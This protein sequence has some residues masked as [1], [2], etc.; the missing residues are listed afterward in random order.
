M[1][2]TLETEHPQADGLGYLLHKHPGKLQSF[3]QSFGHAHVFYPKNE[4]NRSKIAILL[5]VDPVGLVRRKGGPSGEGF[6]LDQYVN[7]RGYVAS[8]FMSVTLADLFSTAMNGRCKDKPELVETV[9]PFIAHLPALPCRGG[10]VFL[11]SLFEPLGYTVEAQCGLLD[12][13]FPEW[14]FSNCLNVSL[15]GDF[16]IQDLLKHLYVLIPVLDNDKHYWVGEDEVEKL[17]KRGEGWLPQHPLKAHIVNRYL[18]FQKRLTSSALE[19]LVSDSAENLDE[20]EAEHN[21]QEEVFEKALSLNEQRM[22]TVLASLKGC[23]AQ[24]VLDLGCGEGN[25]LRLLLQEKQFTEIVGMDVSHRVLEKA[26]ARLKLDRLPEFQKNRIKFLHGSLI[27]RDE[28]LQGFD[29]AALVEVIEHLDPPR[30]AALERTV[31]EFAKPKTVIITTPNAEYNV[32]F[33]TLPAGKFR[34]KDHR[35]EWTREEFETW[36]NRVGLEKGYTVQF[37]PIGNVA[38]NVGAP[39]QMASFNSIH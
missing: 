20:V 27:Y 23:G 36:A 8:S 6:S 25:L 24:R 28:R 13:K 7:D 22:G 15:R 9:F 2:L 17:L 26:S 38:I 18:K 39:T 31:F 5:D 33:D 4:P 34:H 1:L 37:L 29:A 30:L 35:F 21:A 11:R 32:K 16:R 14:G 12:A 3:P 19:Q 10:E